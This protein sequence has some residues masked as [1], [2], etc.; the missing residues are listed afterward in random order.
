LCLGMLGMH[1]GYWANMA[2][3]EA[4]LIVA[5]G[6][7]FDDRVTGALDKFAPNAK[8]IHVDVD[9]SSIHKNVRAD[10]AILGDARTVTRQV[11]D[12]LSDEACR[13]SRTRL[14][15]WWRRIDD[16]RIDAPLTYVRSTEVIKPQ[17]LCET[18]YSLT[19]GDAIVSTDVGQHQM[20]FAQY[21]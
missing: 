20:W 9:P 5:I 16:W 17:F 15:A 10:V 21:H 3:S 7:R 1:G 4:D 18:L 12:E 14:A 6:V 2:I 8:V 13:T 19:R 11:L